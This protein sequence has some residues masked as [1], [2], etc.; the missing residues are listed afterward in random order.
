MRMK[1]GWLRFDEIDISDPTFDPD[2]GTRQW[3]MTIALDPAAFSIGEEPRP[4]VWE[5]L[6]RALHV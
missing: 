5:R 4:S 1:G 3:A 2:A 6:R